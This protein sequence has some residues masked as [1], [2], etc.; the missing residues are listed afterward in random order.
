MELRFQREVGVGV[1]L[2]V[3]AAVFVFLLMWLRGRSFRSGEIVRVTFSDVAGLKEGDW[4]RTSGV[5]VG[6][7]K[8]VV[9]EAPGQVSVY[10]DVHGDRAQL[11]RV[12]ARASVRALDLFGARYVEYSPGTASAQLDSLQPIHG[13][14]DQDITDMAQGLSGQGRDLLAN[15]IELTSPS[16]AAELRGVLAEA[17]RTIQQLGELG[18]GP[19]R[20][21]TN[22]L[23]SLRQVFQRLDI[24]L[25]SNTAPATQTMQ[26]MR[27]ASANM[28]QVPTTLQRTSLTL[29]SLMTRISSGRGTLGQL[30]NDT[31]LM[32]DL[33][34]T[35]TALADL[36]V[37]FRTNPRKY[38][39][40]RIF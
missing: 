30:V 26:H 7:V 40:V 23:V 28:E 18:Q 16:T 31:T 38:I 36:L 3:A 37:D 39:N 4:V 14:R 35:N 12:D 6:K 9:L 21:L 2:V 25:A 34:R 11:P 24:L 22:A 32:T 10:L 20:E 15:A 1:M 13:S 5:N 27:D 19:S 33:R 8:R 17:R 29:D